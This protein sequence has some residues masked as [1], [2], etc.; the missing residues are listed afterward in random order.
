[1]EHIEVSGRNIAFRRKGLGSPVVLLH[2]F[3]GD[4]RM[5]R[6]Q[7]EGLSAEYTVVAWDGP[8]AGRSDD[9]P[10]TFRLPDYADALAGFLAAV[11]LSRAHVVG[12]SY[13][14]ALALEFYRRYPSVPRTL[15][16]AGAY[17]GWAGSLPPESV[18]DR[19]RQSLVLADQPPDRLVRSLLPTMFSASVPPAI[20]DEFARSIRESHPAG[21]RSM[22]RAMA[23][24]DL[25]DVLRRIEVPTLLLYGDQDVRAPLAVGEAIH[26]AIPDSRLVVI[27]GA[28]HVSC[29]E[30]PDRFNAEVRAFLPER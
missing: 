13:G 16:L 27:E 7:L 9:P 17:A 28:G 18:A 11:G 10:D 14:G 22:A 23:E 26:A 6:W 1:M 25:R 3:V 15:V 19:L 12:L 2:G 20:A 5:W 29:M 24:A 21:L 8:G 4:S 30:V